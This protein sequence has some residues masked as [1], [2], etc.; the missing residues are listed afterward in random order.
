MIDLKPNVVI[1]SLEVF[2][3]GGTLINGPIYYLKE[4]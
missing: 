4:L 3:E 1:N 2:L